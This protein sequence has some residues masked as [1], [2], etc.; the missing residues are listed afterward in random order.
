[1]ICPEYNILTYYLK[2]WKKISDIPLSLSLSQIFYWTWRNLFMP[3]EHFL[4]NITPDFSSMIF[5]MAR[6]TVCSPH[7]DFQHPADNSLYDLYLLVFKQKYHLVYHIRRGFLL[8]GLSVL[9]LEQE[10]V[11]LFSAQEQCLCWIVT[12]STRGSLSLHLH[13]P[14]QHPVQNSIQD[15]KSLRALLHSASSF[16]SPSTEGVATAVS[17]DTWTSF[18]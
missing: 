9:S 15:T 1:M 5:P 12:T 2:M 7:R 16:T 14:V 8:Q 13:V 18:C 11:E 6:H 10:T 4:C 3:R 17:G